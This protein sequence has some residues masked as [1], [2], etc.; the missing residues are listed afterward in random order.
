MGDF[1]EFDIIE[2]HAKEAAARKL[3][4]ALAR[5]AAAQAHEQRETAE[6]KARST[7]FSLETNE[8]LRLAE[9][10]RYGVEPLDGFRVSIG[11]LFKFGWKVV[12]IS[13]ERRLV[14]PPEEKPRRKTREDYYHDG[15]T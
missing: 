7:E 9:Y 3:E 15:G 12:E 2:R 1:D 11:M 5:N 13:G 14:P 6:R 4:D 8:R 10:D